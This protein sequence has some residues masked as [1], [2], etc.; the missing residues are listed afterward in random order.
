MSTKRRGVRLAAVL[1]IYFIT[2]YQLHRLYSIKC[3]REYEQ[4]NPKNAEVSSRNVFQNTR[5]EVLRKT[6]K[7]SVRRA[8]H[9]STN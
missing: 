6:S 9:W 2:F 7:A 5:L 4:R 8:V 3:Y 1:F